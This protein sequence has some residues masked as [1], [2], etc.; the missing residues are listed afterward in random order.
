M[1]SLPYLAKQ[2][3]GRGRAPEL[4]RKRHPAAGRSLR[5]R[6]AHAQA[7]ERGRMD[8]RT[9]GIGAQILREV[10]RAQNATAWASP[11]A[12]PAWPATGWKSPATSPRNKTIP[13]CKKQ[14]KAQRPELNG[15]G[16][17]I[18][19]VQARFNDEHHQY[20]GLMPA[21]QS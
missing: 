20:P 12:C 13:L 10:R 11:A 15:M 17:H 19:I 4:R 21:W 1:S 14:K 5:A 16:L 2:R 8:L 3:Q 9:Y 7:P 6:P 18:G